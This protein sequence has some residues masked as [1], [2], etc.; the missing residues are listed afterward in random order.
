M[1]VI[2]ECQMQACT[3]LPVGSLRLYSP[4]LLHRLMSEAGKC[5]LPCISCALRPEQA[6]L[7]ISAA[8]ILRACVHT[9]VS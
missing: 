6:S 9:I 3:F 4:V 7:M 5:A 2:I 1:E 8:N